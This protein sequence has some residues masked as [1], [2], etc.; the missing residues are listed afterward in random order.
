MTFY[1]LWVHID[2]Y[3]EEYNREEILSYGKPSGLVLGLEIK[4][5]FNGSELITASANANHFSSN[6]ESCISL[7]EEL[8]KYLNFHSYGILYVWNDEDKEMY[9]EFQVWRLRHGKVEKCKDTILSPVE[10]EE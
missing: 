2:D 10:L 6:V 3:N 5:I 8:P 1:H 4:V 7:F 9:N